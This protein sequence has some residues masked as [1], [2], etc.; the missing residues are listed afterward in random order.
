MAA[1]EYRKLDGL[2]DWSGEAFSIT[3]AKH[4]SSSGG[5]NNNSSGSSPMG[6]RFCFSRM[7]F[8]APSSL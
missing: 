5:S 1:L 8:F 6:W 2:E 3:S 7:E 4:D